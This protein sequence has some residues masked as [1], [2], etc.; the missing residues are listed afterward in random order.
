MRFFLVLSILTLSAFVSAQEK[1]ETPPRIVVPAPQDG[2]EIDPAQVFMELSDG[3]IISLEDWSKT[4]L[5]NSGTDLAIDTLA[6][7][8]QTGRI[9]QLWSGEEIS[10]GARPIKDP[11]LQMAQLGPSLED[12]P[13]SVYYSS[14][15]RNPDGS[16]L[17]SIWCGAND[18]ATGEGADRM[19]AIC[20]GGFGGNVDDHILKR[21]GSIPS[22]GHWEVQETIS[23]WLQ[24]IVDGKN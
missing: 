11:V 7:D 5:A 19:H 6:L 10:L 12:I 23:S 17:T 1:V 21:A 3:R 15:G 9:A 20:T 18:S 16:R 4:I 22:A 2:K 13:L 14:I 24:N 8:F